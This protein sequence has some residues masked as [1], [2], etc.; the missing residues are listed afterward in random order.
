MLY[1][2]ATSILVILTHLHAGTPVDSCCSTNTVVCSNCGTH[3]WPN[4]YTCPEHQETTGYP[5]ALLPG[6]RHTYRHE[7]VLLSYKL[8]EYA[9]GDLVVG[10]QSTTS[11]QQILPNSPD[12]TNSNDP[13]QSDKEAL[14]TG[15]ESVISTT[16]S[17]ST[18][19]SNTEDTGL[20]LPRLL[21][22]YADGALLIG[23]EGAEF[24]TSPSDNIVNLIPS[25]SSSSMYA[26][27]SLV[28][29]LQGARF[30]T[31]APPPADSLAQLHRH[32]EQ[33]IEGDR[34][35]QRATLESH[36]GED[37]GFGE[38]EVGKTFSDNVRM[39]T[40]QSHDFVHPKD[41]ELAEIMFPHN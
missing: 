2:V 18:D 35:L 39:F 5:Q 21:H 14:T 3:L 24:P 31:P 7:L 36:T 19:S 27:G 16:P 33:E 4:M 6:N 32:A 37:R 26:E 28:I 11:N 9:E 15:L 12:I 30:V 1:Y 40:C 25:R 38:M 13:T 8:S 17:L 34:G 23:P 20:N 29:G 22:E 41:H 10:T